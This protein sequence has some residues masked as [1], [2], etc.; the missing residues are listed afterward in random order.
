MY[1]S[2]KLDTLWSYE[3]SAEQVAH[4]LRRHAGDVIIAPRLLT[5]YVAFNVHGPPFADRRIRRAF[6]LA[7]DQ[8]TLVDETTKRTEAAPA[9]GGFVPPGMPG[10]SADIGL[11]FDQARARQLLAAAGFPDGKAF[12]AVHLLGTSGSE[13]VCE[14]LQAGWRESLGVEVE[15]VV[16][17][18]ADFHKALESGSWQLFVLG[19]IADFP[20]P[21]NF[22][23]VFWQAGSGRRI[24]W[25]NEEY[26]QLLER[27][28]ELLNQEERLRLYQRADRILI[29]EAPIMPLYYTLASLLVKPWVKS[30]PVPATAS[31][32]WKDVVIA[33]HA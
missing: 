14:Y 12:P 28:R 21:D 22:L 7:I 10:H 24:G 6:A 13:S 1:E 15:R 2:G 27:A 25:R 9:A 32:Y 26:D 17:E 11:P 20:D 18:W 29:A 19:W 8:E 23:R 31:Y 5:D 3:F 30:F 33:P 16:V 4:V